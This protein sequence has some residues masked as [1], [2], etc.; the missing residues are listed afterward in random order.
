LPAFAAGRAEKPFIR[1]LD[2]IAAARSG[3]VLLFACDRD[4][5]LTFLDGGLLPELPASLLGHSLFS[6]LEAYPELLEL[7]RRLLGGERL[8]FASIAFAQHHL[9]LWAVPLRSESGEPDGATGIIIDIS[10]RVAAER[11]VLDAA[12]REMALVEHASDLI[13]VMAPDGLLLSAN[14]AAHRLLGHMPGATARRSSS[15]LLSIPKITTAYGATSPR[16]PSTR[17]A[18]R[19]SSTASHT[20]MAPGAPSSRS[21]TT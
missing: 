2:S 3:P 18:R 15:S 8:E 9:E 14:P 13:F 7:G 5:I 21:P 19:R 11:S 20:P 4:G 1:V 12:R 16:R 10:A 17:G 6:I